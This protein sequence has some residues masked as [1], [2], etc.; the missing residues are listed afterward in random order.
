MTQDP[1]SAVKEV[2]VGTVT[3]GGRRP[4]VLIAG[5]CVIESE[6]ECLETAGFLKELTQA[7]RIP[8][9]FK[10]SYDKA[11]R[12]S[13]RSYRGPGYIQGLEILGKVKRELGVPVLSDV[14]RFEEVEAAAEVLDVLQVPAFLCRQTDFVLAIAQTGKG[15]NVK[16]GQFLAPWDVRN[17]LEKIETTGNQSILVTERGASFGYNNLVAD[18]RSLVILRKMG[19]PVIFDVTHSLQLPGGLGTSSGGQREFISAL[20][21]AG[22]AVGI[23]GLF[24]E[25]HP[26]PQAA[27]CDGPN[28]QPLDSLSPLLEQLMALDRVV[29]EDKRQSA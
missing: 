15:V 24:M 12:S 29:K 5:P 20:A 22:V 23:D 3:L 27:L 26:N 7:L 11:N 10:S 14:H 21:R 1:F 25:V 13:L 17:I 6:A 19:Y 28:S 18:M 4:L 16:K 2:R 8:F 9:I